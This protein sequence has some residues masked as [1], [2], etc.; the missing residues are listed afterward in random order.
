[1]S[2]IENKTYSF[3]NTLIFYW[4]YKSVSTDHVVSVY[5]RSSDNNSLGKG[6]ANRREKRGFNYLPQDCNLR[7][8]GDES[9]ES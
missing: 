1:M 2:V 5:L 7:G 9:T 4:I 6:L 3:L 8:N